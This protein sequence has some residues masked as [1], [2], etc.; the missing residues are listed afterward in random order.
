MNIFVL[1]LDPQKAVQYLVDKHVVKMVLETAQLLCSP[2]DD[3]PYR[4]THYN[5]PCAKWIRES[6][7]NYA[8]LLDYGESI[9]EEYTYRYD[10][11]HKSSEVIEWCI[12]KFDDIKFPLYDCLETTPFALAM[13]EKYQSNDPVDSYRNYY[14]NEKYKLFSWKK[15]EK[16]DWL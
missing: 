12:E 15:R 16:P 5:H 8:W 2:F 3:A 1:D 7:T 10:K 6:P 4:R 11:I 14:R 13:P 9:S